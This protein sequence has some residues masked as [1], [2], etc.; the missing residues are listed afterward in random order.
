MIKPGWRTQFLST[1]T[2]P[3]VAYLLMLLGIY[4][5]FFEL[6]NPGFVLP[7]VV[8]A[9]SML[10]A[11][12]ALQ[13]LPIN[14]TGLGLILLGVIFI[15]AEGVTPSFGVLGI[16]GTISFVLGSVLLMNTTH[17]A[18]QIAWSI[19]L[20]MAVINIFLFVMLC[21]MA[22]RA[23]KRETRH[24]LDVLIGAK[25]RALGDI[26]LEGQ[27]IIRGE[28]WGVCAQHPIAADKKI[29]VTHAVGLM[30]EVEEDNS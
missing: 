23:R 14:Y 17:I 21:G 16:G 25:G 3:T 13:L 20:S 10:V 12:Y 5:I 4:G 29:K 26:H 22:Y 15:I 28:I 8:G 19:I 2:N 7:G 9:V 27:A 1:I 30:L 6:V 11:L 18:Y 24:G